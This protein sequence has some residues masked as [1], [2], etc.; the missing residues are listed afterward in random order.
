MKNRKR[1]TGIVLLAMVI[2]GSAWML[3]GTGQAIGGPH[4]VN[5]EW[6]VTTESQARSA[7]EGCTAGFICKQWC[8][9]GVPTNGFMCFAG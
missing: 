9:D 6:L 3:P 5:G 2:F 8:L 4:D 1:T 7:I